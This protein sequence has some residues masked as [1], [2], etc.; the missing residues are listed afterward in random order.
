MSKKAKNTSPSLCNVLP[1]IFHFFLLMSDCL[2]YAIHY[3]SRYPKTICDTRQLLHRKWFSKEDIDTA[4]PQLEKSWY[5]DD[6]AYVRAY[7]HSEVSRK[8]KPALLIKQKLLMKGIEKQLLEECIE[9][10]S[11]EMHTGQAQKIAKE[12]VRLR[13]KGKTDPEIVQALT[14]KWWRYDE[15][16]PLLK[17]PL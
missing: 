7:L 10:L 9:E 1:S 2:T 14:R 8:G 13:D 4:I 11:E 5:L 3:L 12:I 17:H 15:I 16:L 6:L